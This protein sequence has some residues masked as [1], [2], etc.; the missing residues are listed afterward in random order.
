M[1]LQ[2]LG[3]CFGAVQLEDLSDIGWFELATGTLVGGDTCTANLSV[4]RE[5]GVGQV[6]PNFGEGATIRSVHRRSASFWSAP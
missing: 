2:V 5:G 4:S 3:D 6:D 1:E